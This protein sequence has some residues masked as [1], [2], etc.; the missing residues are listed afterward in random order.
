MSRSRST[1]DLVERGDLDD[2]LRR[3]DDL[4][5]DADWDGL[6]DLRDRCRKA[7]ERGRQLWPAASHAEYRLALQAPGQWSAA[8]LEAGAG[9]FALGP[10]PEVAA[11]THSWQELADHAPPTPE[12][13][14]AAHERVVR[15]D[16]LSGD[17]KV[18]PEVLELPLRL[19][20]WEPAYPVAV[21]RPYEAEFPDVA[22]PAMDDVDLPAPGTPIDDP[23]AC[24]ALE[25]LASTWKT[26]SNGQVD[27]AAVTGDAPSA[28]AALGVERA[29]FGAVDPGHALAVMAWTAASGGAH[30][31]RRG[32]ASGRVSAWWT[33]AALAG[34]LERWPFVPDD[35]GTAAH[36]VTWYRWDTGGPGIGWTLGLAAERGDARAWAVWARDHT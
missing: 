9:R 1:G 36:A 22:A 32:G 11:S 18:S 4:C 25:E 6:V 31:R 33:V 10:L 34:M 12:A 2:L 29:R 21:Y 7:L 23:E 26:E 3:I 27:V 17:D 24:R 30:G 8:V 14:L 20:D 16:D 35:V 15:G 28:V 13:A 19:Q 5:D